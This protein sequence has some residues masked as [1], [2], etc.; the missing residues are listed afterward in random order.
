MIFCSAVVLGLSIVLLFVIW[1]FGL[2]LLMYLF[3]LID[4][5]A[6]Q[7]KNR[8]EQIFVIFDLLPFQQLHIEYLQV[9]VEIND[10]AIVIFLHILEVAKQKLKLSLL[11]IILCLF[12]AD[13]LI[14][15]EQDG[16]KLMKRDLNNRKLT[17]PGMNG[18]CSISVNS[19]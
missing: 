19:V 12:V 14:L 15:L 7:I 2:K 5:Y 6:D 16:W 8:I 18:K 10:P 4:E 9:L 13:H 3:A 17:G 1:Y 11:L